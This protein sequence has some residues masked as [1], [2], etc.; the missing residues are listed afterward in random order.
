MKGIVEM[1]SLPNMQPIVPP[2]ELPSWKALEAHYH[3]IRKAHR[4][5]L[6]EEDPKRGDVFTAEAAG[7]F[8]DYSKNRVTRHTI[9]LLIRLPCSGSA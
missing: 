2:S 7:L 5:E 3:E 6:F 9:K 1:Q 4:R 8:F